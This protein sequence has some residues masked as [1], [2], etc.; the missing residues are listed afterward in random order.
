M[1]ALKDDTLESR[2]S[3]LQRRIGLSDACTYRLIAKNVTVLLTQSQQ[4]LRLETY[5]ILDELIK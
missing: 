5:K 4:D 2:A 1:Q 3:L